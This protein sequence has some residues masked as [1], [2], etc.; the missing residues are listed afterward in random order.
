[1]DGETVSRSLHGISGTAYTWFRGESRSVAQHSKLM[2]ACSGFVKQ[3]ITEKRATRSTDSSGQSVLP[4]Y[5][6]T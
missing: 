2:K 4:A 1:M 5:S 6:A 3:D